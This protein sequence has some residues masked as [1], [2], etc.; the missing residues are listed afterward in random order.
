[1][2]P[3]ELVF[4]SVRDRKPLSDMAL[5]M[6]LRGILEGVTVHGFRSSFREW[7]GDET[8]YPRE[9]A[10]HALAHTLGGVEAA[11]RRGDALEKRRAMMKDWSAFLAGGSS[12]ER[13]Q[14]SQVD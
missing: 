1:M 9:I 6:C 11:Y 2:D 10:E 13:V 3:D 4:P 8:V 5:S 7:C 12:E 14:S